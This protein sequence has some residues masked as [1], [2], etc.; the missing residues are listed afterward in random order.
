MFNLQKVGKLMYDLR[1]PNIQAEWK[2]NPEALMDRYG[3][4]EEDRQPIRD[5]V[6]RPF[7]DAGLHPILLGGGARAM[8]MEPMMRRPMP[9][10]AGPLTPEAEERK[11]FADQIAKDWGL[12]TQ[13]PI[14]R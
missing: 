3:L 12:I 9:P 2:A 13:A 8:G 4:S 14:G 6:A 1:Y 5:K 11:K 7:F 10:P